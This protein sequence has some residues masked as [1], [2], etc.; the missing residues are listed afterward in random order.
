LSIEGLGSCRK[1]YLVIPKYFAASDLHILRRSL[2]PQLAQNLRPLIFF[3][4][5]KLAH[6]LVDVKVAAIDDVWSGLKFVRRL[7]DR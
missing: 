1:L 4:A 7:K 2:E 5:V 3:G 6:G